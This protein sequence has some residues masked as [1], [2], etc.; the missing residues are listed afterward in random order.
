M[1]RRGQRKVAD[2]EK[3]ERVEE[4]GELGGQRER[5]GNEMEDLPIGLRDNTGGSEGS[6]R[7][8]RRQR[9]R[10]RRRRERWRGNNR[11]GDQVIGGVGVA[12][13]TLEGQKREAEVDRRQGRE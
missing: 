8:W 12:P 5:R 4:E 3:V 10:A 1:T 9:R 13:R 7:W 11:G 6:E 2:R